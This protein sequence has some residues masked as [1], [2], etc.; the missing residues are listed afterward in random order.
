MIAKATASDP[1]GTATESHHGCWS[2][3]SSRITLAG[4]R[5]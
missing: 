2:R 3:R 1:T 4:L 5:P